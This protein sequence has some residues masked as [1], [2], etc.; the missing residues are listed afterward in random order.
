MLAAM[1]IAMTKAAQ[2]TAVGE[3]LALG[4][5]ALKVGN[6]NGSKMS[7]E[8]AFQRAWRDWPHSRRFP[9]VH[10]DVARNDLL[11]I[12]RKSEGRRSPHLSG[13]ASQWPFVPYVHG[14]W[15]T[16]EIG[17]LL[18]LSSGVPLNAWIEL[19]RA[20]VDNLQGRHG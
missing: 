10:A 20:F 14:D 9:V 7:V 16:E 17:E 3:G 5:V 12:I 15:E 1:P 6:F 8:L 13:W 4:L 11:R 18:E 19:A 2:E